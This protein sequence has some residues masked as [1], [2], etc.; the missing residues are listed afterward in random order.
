VLQPTV[1]VDGPPHVRAVARDQD[2][3]TVVHV[4]NLNVTRVDPFHDV[5]TPAENVTLEVAT[6]FEQIGAVRYATPDGDGAFAALEFARMPAEFG[7]RIRCTI[8]TLAVS[9][10]LVIESAK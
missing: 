6:P 10:I 1:R 4:M 5:V 8:P 7:T 2:T 9:G 3:Q